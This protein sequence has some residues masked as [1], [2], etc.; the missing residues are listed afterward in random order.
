MDRYAVIGHPVAHSRSPWIHAR[1]AQQTGE[2][3]RY[4]AIDAN[5]DEFVA[6]VRE[7]F[8]DGGRGLNVTLPHKQAACALAEVLSPAARAAG[9]VNT[10][11]PDADGRLLG[12]NTDGA[13]LV[14]DLLANLGWEIA[15]RRVLL[16]GAGGAARGVLGPL[17]AQAP[18]AVWLVNRTAAR[19]EQLLADAG[20]PAAARAGGYDALQGAGA[21]D[22]LINAT[23]AGII[24]DTPPLLAECIADHSVCYDMLYGPGQTPFQR[25][26]LLHGAAAAEQGLGM[27]VEQ[28]AESFSLW[29]GVRPDTAAVLADLRR[30]LE[31]AAA[32]HRQLKPPSDDA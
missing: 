22:L 32:D 24:G 9:A 16:V 17:L 8:A 2:S 4:E 19:A 14:R 30:V 26:A 13:G 6:T 7:F 10:L 23:S 1:F 31:A 29:R 20:H 25:W 27:L 11:K 3:L 28:A 21:F 15:G 12:D 5:P 18:A